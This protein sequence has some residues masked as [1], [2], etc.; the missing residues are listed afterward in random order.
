VADSVESP[1]ATSMGER[2]SVMNA[3]HRAKEIYQELRTALPPL[4][5]GYLATQRWFGGKARQIRSA[6]ITD[7]VPLTKT[8]FE[9]FVL[10][11]RLEYTTGP[12][13]MYVLPLIW[14]EEPMA[15]SASTDLKVHSGARGTDLHLRNALTDDEFLRSLLDAIEKRAAFSGSAGEIRASYTSVFPALCGTTAS[16]LQPRPIKAEQSNSSIIYGDRAVLKF[17][18]RTAEGENPDLEIGRFL[19]EERRFP[20]IP[21]VAGWIAYKGKDDSEM[22]LGILQAFVPNVG[23]AW[24]F[25]LQALS[26]FWKEAEKYSELHPGAMLQNQG[27]EADDRQNL[28]API[29]NHISPYLDAVSRLGKRTAELHLALGAES[30]DPSFVSE[31]YTAS[32][33]RE[34]K[35][36]LQGLAERNFALLAMKLKELPGELRDKANDLIARQ[37]EILRG[38]DRVLGNPIQAM[39]TR[40]HG[41]YHLGQVLY[42]GSDFVIIDFEGEP[43]RPLSERRIK[44]SP[45][46]DVAGM[47]R[48]FHYAAFSFH[49][50]SPDGGPAK[51]I[52]SY[53]VRPWAGT[54]YACVSE[55]FLNAYFENVVGA[56]FI[57]PDHDELFSLL[58]LHLLEKAVY[59][60]GYELNNRP[61]WVAIPLEGISQLLNS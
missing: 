7:I 11:A 55:R 27:P 6:E 44:R 53:D 18:R 58:R 28:P 1:R 14:S 23:D 20:N 48:S 32:F 39:R 9:A 43:A 31:P 13:E 25:T 19:T 54:W 41:D 60:L 51:E 4:L 30:T 37:D 36:A 12:G 2:K 35:E 47:L 26:S 15:E 52:K 3:P 5:P 34:F 10:L 29:I 40:I 17:F 24:Q 59:E 42:T 16:V 8:R 50:A 22:S 56:A 21:A 61:A 49:L 46:Q 45:L 33:Q 38:Y 57:P